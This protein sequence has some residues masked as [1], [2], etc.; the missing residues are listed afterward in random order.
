MDLQLT[1]DCYRYHAGLA[2][3]IH[4]DVIPAAGP[5]LAYTKKDPVGVAG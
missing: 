1:I 4:G 2:D 3:K 5:Y